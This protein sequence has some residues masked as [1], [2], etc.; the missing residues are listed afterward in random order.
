MVTARAMS[1][2]AGYQ[3]GA[4]F[5]ASICLY[6]FSPFRPRSLLSY[7]EFSPLL[8][9]DFCYSGVYGNVCDFASII[10]LTHY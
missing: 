10:R 2:G 1:G 4:N 5:P 3:L 6:P 9:S 7:P 8:I